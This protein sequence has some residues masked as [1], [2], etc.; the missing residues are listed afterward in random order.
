[1]VILKF[2]PEILA[3]ILAEIPCLPDLLACGL[4]CDYFHQVLKDS[5][6]LQY[7][8]ELEKSGMVNN[9]FCTLPTTMRLKMLRERELAWSHFNWKFINNNI[10]VPLESSLI[11]AGASSVLVI[12]L[13]SVDVPWGFGTKG[14]QS[15]TLPSVDDEDLSVAWKTA[16]VGEDILNFGLAIEEHDLLAYIVRQVSIPI[17]VFFVK[18]YL[19]PSS[20]CSTSSREIWLVLRHHSDPSRPHGDASVPRILICRIGPDRDIY[21]DIPRVSIRISGQ[22]IA[23][24]LEDE[25]PSQR[26]FEAG[27]YLYVFDWKT[28]DNKGVSQTILRAIRRSFN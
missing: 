10:T 2:P 17:P 27:N 5:T 4:V 1:M 3:E 19:M 8:I 28:G 7:R 25:H 18:K 6:R 26:E 12:G 15:I 20:S 16:D 24:T 22:N 14:F 23:V 21:I 11:H 13:Q 9:S